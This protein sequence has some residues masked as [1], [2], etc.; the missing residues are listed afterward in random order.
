VIV[1]LGIRVISF[2][3]EAG[4]FLLGSGYPGTYYVDQT[5][6]EL[7]SIHLPLP[8]PSALVLKACTTI[9]IIVPFSSLMGFS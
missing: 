4:L 8:L 1:Q 5:G 6:L 9:P 3:F 7:I 2:I